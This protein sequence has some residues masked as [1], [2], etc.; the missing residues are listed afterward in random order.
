MIFLDINASKKKRKI[1]LNIVKDVIKECFM[2][3]GIGGGINT[4]EDINDLL[5]IGADKVVVKTAAIE[6][7]IFINEASKF[8]VF[9][10]SLLLLMLSLIKVSIIFII[11]V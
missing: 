9:N 4:I 1:N 2:P 7:P 8:L 11:K 6:N 10:V 3:I 5:K